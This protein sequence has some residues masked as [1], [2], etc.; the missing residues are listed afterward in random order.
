AHAWMIL[1][2]HDGAHRAITRTAADRW[3]CSI[4]AGLLI[5]PLYGEA[6]RKYH[7]LHHKHT[8]ERLDPLFSPAKRRLYERSRLLYMVLDVVPML[9]TF[10]CKAEPAPP[11]WLPM[12]KKYM[13][14][15]VAASAV[16]IALARPALG[17]VVWTIVTLYAW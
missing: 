9:L 11:G 6:F 4:G 13:A 7:L 10:V 17:F 3:I 2:V 16:T 14:A 15:G 5:M 12:E 8:N 1:L